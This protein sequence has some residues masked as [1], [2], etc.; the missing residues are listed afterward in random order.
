MSDDFLKAELKNYLFI[1]V[2]AIFLAAGMVGFLIPNKIATGGIAG[3]SIIL[4]HLFE[5]PTG[6]ILM[7]VNIPL[8][9]LSLNYLGKNLPLEPSLPL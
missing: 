8:L 2:G 6:V 5:L 4:H 1:I 3:L 7:L 9:L